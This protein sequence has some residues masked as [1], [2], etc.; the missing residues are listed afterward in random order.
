MVAGV[1]VLQRTLE[2]GVGPLVLVEGLEE[3]VGSCFEVSVGFRFCG[4]GDGACR[5][6]IQ[7]S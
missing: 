3:V 2:T 7:R 1:V 6:L 5:Y 4:L